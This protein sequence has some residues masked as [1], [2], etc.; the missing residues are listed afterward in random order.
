MWMCGCIVRKGTL[1]FPFRFIFLNTFSKGMYFSL[2]TCLPSVFDVQEISLSRGF[3]S[4]P[5]TEN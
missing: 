5:E 1:W 2:D 4:R 3:V